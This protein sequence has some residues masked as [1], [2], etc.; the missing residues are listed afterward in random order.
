MYC[1]SIVGESCYWIGITDMN[2]QGVWTGL[3]DNVQVNFTAWGPGEPNG[4]TTEDCAC[5]Y[6]SLQYS[7]IDAPCTGLNSHLCEYRP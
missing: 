3:N 7:W 6:K 2:K 1:R 4:G 5:L